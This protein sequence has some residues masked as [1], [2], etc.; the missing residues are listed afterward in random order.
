MLLDL[1][2]LN[3]HKMGDTVNQKAI[4]H[5]RASAMAKVAVTSKHQSI[6]LGKAD[7]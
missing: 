3:L 4:R 7:T 6:I 2:R 5:S 1:N